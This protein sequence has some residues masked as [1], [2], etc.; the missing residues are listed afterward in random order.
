MFVAHAGS[1]TLQR[2]WK[3][4]AFAVRSIADGGPLVYTLGKAGSI[5]AWAAL[6]LPTTVTTA[7]RRDKAG[8]LQVEQLQVCSSAMP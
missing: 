1:C 7:W 3:A 8:C 6:E 2:S 5:K 4:H